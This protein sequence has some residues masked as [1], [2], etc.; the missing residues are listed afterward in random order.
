MRKISGDYDRDPL[1]LRW[2]P[3]SASIY[4][5]ADD[6]GSRNILLVAVAG[7]GVKPV[8]TGTHV[9][10]MDS[11]SSDL[12]AVG[13]RS[14]PENPPDVVRYNLRRP[15]E[16]AKLTSVNAGLLSGKHLAKTEEINFTSRGNAK[17]QG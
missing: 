8:T 17:V 3:D 6:H 14:D 7:G 16:I 9:L 10:T 1:N 11:A 4:F 5:D 12:M 13:T 15:G 2:S